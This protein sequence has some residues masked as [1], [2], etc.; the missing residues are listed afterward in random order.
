MFVSRC[1]VDK[2]DVFVR[3]PW[4]TRTQWWRHTKRLELVI[5]SQYE[6]SFSS[7][8]CCRGCLKSR[9]GLRYAV[10]PAWLLWG[11]L[12]VL[13]GL[14]MFG[15]VV[16]YFEGSCVMCAE[17]RLF[18]G[19]SGCHACIDVACCEQLAHLWKLLGCYV[20]SDV[21]PTAVSVWRL[22]NFFSKRQN[23]AYVSG[24]VAPHLVR[25]WSLVWA[26]SPPTW[27]FRV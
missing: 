4:R 6:A 24:P 19:C 9:T 12:V 25:V 27:V 26:T 14:F 3:N 7:F 18:E 8:P 13:H 10:L 23:H 15:G 20:C 21:E 11:A 1:N 2:C 22:K 5:P 17:K 16:F